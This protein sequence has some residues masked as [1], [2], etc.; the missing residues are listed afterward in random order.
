MSSKRNEL[1]IKQK[2][3]LI[4]DYQNGIKQIEL[5]NKYRVGIGTVSKIIK[6]R[7]KYLTDSL[8][9]NPKAKRIRKIDDNN[10]KLNDLVV[11]FIR[12][13][14]PLAMRYPKASQI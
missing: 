10:K 6:D 13:S 2:R 11:S 9:I 3:K 7:N 5:K 12:C 8:N 4:Q 14:T 1:T